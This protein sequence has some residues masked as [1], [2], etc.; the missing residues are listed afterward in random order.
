MK[1][2]GSLENRR[3]AHTVF[4][5]AVAELF[6]AQVGIMFCQRFHRV[7]MPKTASDLKG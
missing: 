6:V 4:N 5:H 1:T 3:L 2:L 7:N